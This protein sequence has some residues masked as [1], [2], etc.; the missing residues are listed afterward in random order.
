VLLC[1]ANHFDAIAPASDAI[2]EFLIAHAVPEDI[3]Y[4]ARLV[5]EELVS[6]AI[7]YAY[8]DDLHHE[9]ELHTEV[10]DDVFT[11]S[12]HDDGHP[13]DPNS[14]PDPDTSLPAAERPIGGLGLYLVRSMSD[15]M[16]YSRTGLKNI[17]TIR[18]SFAKSP[19]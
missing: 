3:H 4:L 5:V 12:I 13:F 2:E 7:K 1:L 9:I 17:V 18:K 6:N 19:N 10:Q 16:E 14:L 15:S 11:L 8:D